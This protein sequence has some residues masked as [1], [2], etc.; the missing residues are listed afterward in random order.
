MA[1]GYFASPITTTTTAPTGYTVRWIDWEGTI[2]KTE[3]IQYGQPATPPSMTG[4]SHE[5]LTFSGWTFESSIYSAVTSNLDIGAYYSDDGATYLYIEFDRSGGTTG[6]IAFTTESTNQLTTFE[7]GDGNVTV[8]SNTGKSTLSGYTYS[9]TGATSYVIKI[10]SAGQWCL[11]W[12][13]TTLGHALNNTTIL[14]KVIYGGG[15]TVR[16]GYGVFDTM[17]NL[18]AIHMSYLKSTEVQ[19]AYIFSYCYAL[20][21]ITIHPNVS[22]AFANSSTISPA[23]MFLNAGLVSICAPNTFY[24]NGGNVFNQNKFVDINLGPYPSWVAASN[25][26]YYFANIYGLKNLTLSE[27]E[28]AVQSYAFANCYA[29]ENINFSKVLTTIS[30]NAFENCYSIKKVLLY[31]STTT[32]GSNAFN[33]CY[34]IKELYIPSV[35]SIGAN[36]FNN[37]VALTGVTLSSGMT[38]IPNTLFNGCTAL[39]YVILPNKLTSIG[40]SSFNAN[41]ALK[42]IT[43]PSGVTSIGATAF[44]NCLNLSWMNFL[45][46][47]PPT[48]TST[49]FNNMSKRTKIYVP[50]ASVN[51]YKNATNWTAYI[52]YIYPVSQKP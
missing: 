39:E 29:L 25:R 45:P 40:T 11:G 41:F 30:N 23:N 46:T 20:R 27:R 28:T 47:T 22:A 9:N 51:A 1:T 34:S 32:I 12:S 38:T 52:G 17:I 26:T 36:C 49:T 31:N 13:G 4:I 16:L 14:K 35:T 3:K 10:T 7:W 5:H 6:S 43:I 48:I 33:N 18:E 50:D 8:S 37:C 24:I 15:N 42:D 44:Q 2:L 21:H 19:S